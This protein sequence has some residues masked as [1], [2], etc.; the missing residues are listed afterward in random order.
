MG[1]LAL[2]DE[3]IERIAAHVQRSSLKR[4][5]SPSIISLGCTCRRLHMLLAR[6]TASELHWQRYASP[7]HI[8]MAMRFAR[9]YLKVTS[10]GAAVSEK[11]ANAFLWSLSSQTFPN[12]TAVDFGSFRFQ[13]DDNILALNKFLNTS[14]NTL[15]AICIVATKEVVRTFANAKLLHIAHLT[16]LG[17]AQHADVDVLLSS[18]AD[19][20]TK[21][22]TSLTTLKLA[23]IYHLPRAMECNSEYLGKIAPNLQR[24]ELE[25]FNDSGSMPLSIQG[26]CLPFRQ[27]SRVIANCSK[28]RVLVLRRTCITPQMLNDVHAKCPSLSDLRLLECRRYTHEPIS[29]HHLLSKCKDTLTSFTL[30]D[31]VCAFG[32]A[33]VIASQ[34]R[35]L[36]RLGVFLE[37]EANS[38]FSVLCTGLSDT[39][40]ELSV[41][42]NRR[43]NNTS[44]IVRSIQK[45]KKLKCITLSGPRFSADQM[46]FI[47]EHT[48][49]R[50]CTLD[51]YLVFNNGDA[52]VDVTALLHIVCMLCNNIE[53]LHLRCDQANPPVLSSSVQAIKLFSAVDRLSIMAPKLDLSGVAT[54]VRKF[55]YTSRKRPVPSSCLPLVE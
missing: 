47:M 43:T 16:I 44:S 52:I 11:S 33:M 23:Q 3:V 12:I 38:A 4:N 17:Q 35:V 36:K 22:C 19:Q 26:E 34:C 29:I 50:L 41:T 53:N 42:W 49:T 1:F 51:V 15:T 54:L 46:C 9:P 24:L 30:F 27:V 48:G 7:L 8:I 10:L 6:I 2:P 32:D 5:V 25:G 13:T 40:E 20:Q 14:R 37:R 45:T 18:M 55:V 31:S 21:V 39:L 28:L